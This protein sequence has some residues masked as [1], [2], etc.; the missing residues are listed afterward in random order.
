MGSSS[1]LLRHGTK[2]ERVKRL[3]QVFPV[4]LRALEVRRLAVATLAD[5]MNLDPR[6]SAATR[7]DD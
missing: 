1:P 6:L 7:G 2:V 5:L 3:I 4:L